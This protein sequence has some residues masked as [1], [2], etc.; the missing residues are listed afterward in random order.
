MLPAGCVLRALAMAVKSVAE[1]RCG[2]QKR[3][4]YS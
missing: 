3:F 2:L 4:Y 1:S